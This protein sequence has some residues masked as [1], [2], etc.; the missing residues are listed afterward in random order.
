ME[1]KIIVI[2]DSHFSNNNQLLFAEYDPIANFAIVWQQ[3][4]KENPDYIFHLGD[5]SQ[6]GSASSYQDINNILSQANCPVY[7]I[8]GNHDNPANLKYLCNAA[9]QQCDYLDI[10][11]HRFIFVDSNEAGSDLGFISTKE[12]AKIYAHYSLGKLNHLCLHHH[13]TPIGSPADNHQVTNTTLLTEALIELEFCSVL[14]GH[15][16]NPHQSSFGNTIIFHNPSTIV[17]FPLGAQHK[18]EPI[19][20]F[21][22]LYLSESGIKSDCWLKNLNF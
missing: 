19:I 10:G 17:Q 14:T 7:V 2:S 3:V 21:R 13:F 18:N 22:R 9:I 12:I 8:A 5:I 16:H 20:G 6:D 4:L 1:H 11:N 15:V